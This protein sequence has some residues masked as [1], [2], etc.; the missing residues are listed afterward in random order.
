MSATDKLTQ[1]QV[2]GYQGAL[3]S[4]FIEPIYVQSILIGKLKTQINTPYMTIIK[5]FLQ[6]NLKVD[7]NCFKSLQESS[8]K[9]SCY[10]LTI[11]ITMN[12]ITENLHIFTRIAS[13]DSVQINRKVM[14]GHRV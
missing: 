7:A 2:L 6:G 10:D 4:H 9:S 8:S 12:L 11:N 14:Q 1:W 13:N 3:L 5:F